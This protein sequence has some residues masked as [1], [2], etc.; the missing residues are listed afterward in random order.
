MKHT[1]EKSGY[2]LDEATQVWSRPL[3]SG[4]AYT[5]G[6]LVETRIAEIVE[7]VHDLS[8]LSTELARHCTDWPSIYHLSSGRA[9][10]LRPFEESLQMDILEV[11]AGCGA[12]T[13][14][15]GECGGN[16][17]A[18]EGTPKRAAIARSRTRD[19][20]NVN[21]ICE[22]FSQFS[23]DKL[24][25]VVTLI[26]VLEYAAV[27]VSGENPATVLLERARSFLKPGGRLI[28]AIENQLGLKYLAGAPEDH[29]SRPMYGV[30]G[31]Y[32]QFEPRTYGRAALE[33]LI[34]RSGFFASEV[35][36]PFPDY[37]LPAS[38]IS[39]PG[40][41]HP[42]F[43]AATIIAQSLRRDPQL[44][45][46]LTFSPELVWP[47][48]VRNGL[49]MDLS[50]SFLFVA[51]N[52]YKNIEAPQ[53]L[54]WHYSTNRKPEFCK[55]VRFSK[56]AD[57]RIRVHYRKLNEAAR[58]SSDSPLISLIPSEDDYQSGKL[59]SDKLLRI[60]CRDG[61]RMEEVGEYIREFLNILPLADR[62]VVRIT[63]PD[64]DLPG[65]LFDALPHNIVISPNGSATL[66]DKEWTFTGSLTPGFLVYRTLLN[67]LS[68]I[69][70]LGVPAQDYGITPL[71]FIKAAM[72]SVGWQIED[73]VIRSYMDLEILIQ[74]AVTGVSVSSE[75]MHTWLAQEPFTTHNV[76]TALA[77]ARAQFEALSNAYNSI[78][79]HYDEVQCSLS[80]RIAKP[81]FAAERKIRSLNGEK[82]SNL[83][84]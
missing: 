73:N 79:A 61:W 45:P 60:L 8:V 2:T 37:K 25:D 27:F 16:V 39:L 20:A 75:R 14:F 40:M 10:L 76:F 66:I 35:Y 38:V 23:C 4:I 30:E 47:D 49:G 51:H 52:R 77:E 82:Q 31:R 80:W 71:E 64:Q 58:P 9:N 5:D 28:I 34:S 3:Y 50:N 83:D 56:D 7:R 42:Q 19:L 1:L 36:A 48:I 78:S 46:I 18:L 57:G 15:L 65:E 55:E 74:H 12:I 59:L 44:P 63:R 32:Q 13:R 62:E 22:D 11:G 53:E 69:T 26:G 67:S 81:L 21:V 41:R 6:D 70:R 24:F 33:D 84:S 68:T 43:D 54:A 72:A 29:V 17:L